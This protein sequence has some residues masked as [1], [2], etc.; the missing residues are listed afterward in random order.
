[1]H[2]PQDMGGS[3]RCVAPPRRSSRLQAAQTQ[4]QQQP[5]MGISPS[6]EPP[7]A[8]VFETTTTTALLTTQRDTKELSPPHRDTFTEQPDFIDLSR[9]NDPP[10]RRIIQQNVI[11]LS[12]DTESDDVV[13]VSSRIIERPLP[14]YD[15]AKSIQQSLSPQPRPLRAQS[16]FTRRR[17]PLKALEIATLPLAPILPAPLPSLEDLPPAE[18]IGN[19]LVMFTDGSYKSKERK[20]GA[21]VAYDHNKTWF[22]RAIALGVMQGS[23][24]VNISARLR[25]ARRRA[26]I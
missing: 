22:G 10:S 5:K 13:F 25:A 4:K 24:E 21:G 11:D 23:D 1:M 15:P 18:A 17:K 6:K 26:R 16:P 20:G 7:E 12:S 3:S 9:D 14:A 2:F 19:T 8:A